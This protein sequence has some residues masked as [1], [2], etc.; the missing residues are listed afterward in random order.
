[1]TTR[2]TSYSPLAKILH[3]L[4]ALMVIA[5]LIIG[6]VAKNT[7]GPIVKTLFGL[8]K[9]IGLTLLI[10]M[11]IRLFHRLKHKHPAPLPA[12]RSHQIAAWL[13]HITLYALIFVTI[14]VG[15]FMSAFSGHHTEFWGVINVSLP[16]AVNKSLAHLGE[17]IHE[18][19]AW[20]LVVLVSLH[21]LAA[22]YHHFI[23]KDDTLKRMW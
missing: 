3:W 14:L 10:L 19:I 17:F 6:F 11:I 23:C 8:H 20:A 22:L 21:F 16:F 9:S 4:C 7:H 2:A 12:P 13:T 15:W 18:Y 1:M 5:L